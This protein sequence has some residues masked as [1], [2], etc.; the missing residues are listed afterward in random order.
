MLTLGRKEMESLWKELGISPA[1]SNIKWA[2]VATAEVAVS[3]CEELEDQCSDRGKTSFV[4]GTVLLNNA[5]S[6]DQSPAS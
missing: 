4:T 3:S 5:E 6:E 1:M 2:D